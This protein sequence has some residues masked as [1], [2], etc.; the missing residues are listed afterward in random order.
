MLKKEE[1]EQSGEASE[2][3]VKFEKMKILSQQKED[4]EM[5]N[6]DTYEPDD[7]YLVFVKEIDPKT[8]RLIPRNDIYLDD[9]EPLTI[10]AI[11][12]S[13]GAPHNIDEKSIHVF[14]ENSS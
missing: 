12:D 3:N 1:N 5:T 10:K 11:L 13:L 4:Q 8:K 14:V 9:K 2:N 7:K 6:M